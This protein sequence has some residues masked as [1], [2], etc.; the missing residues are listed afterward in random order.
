MKMGFPF[1]FIFQHTFIHNERIDDQGI[2]E[3]DGYE[4][5]YIVEEVDDT[6]IGDYMVHSFT[7]F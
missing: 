2:I 3:E 6:E 7:S 4:D 1:L 5:E